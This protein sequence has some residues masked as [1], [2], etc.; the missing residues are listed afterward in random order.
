MPATRGSSPGVPGPDGCL[1]ETPLGQLLLQVVRIL[2][3]SILVPYEC[4]LNLGQGNVFIPV[5]LFMGGFC[6][7]QGVCLCVIVCPWCGLGLLC[8]W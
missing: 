1:V 3:E 4:T 7:Q 5:C 8:V 6:L 2:L